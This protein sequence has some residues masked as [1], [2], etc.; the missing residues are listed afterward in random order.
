MSSPRS[1]TLPTT[2]DTTASDVPDPDR[3]RTDAGVARC[4]PCVARRTV[5]GAALAGVGLLAGGCAVYGGDSAAPAGDAAAPATGTGGEAPAT[6]AVLAALSDLPVGEGLVLAD[7][8]VVLT[9]PDEDT[10]LGFS[11]VCTHAGCNVNEVA[12]GLIKCP[13]HGSTFS[14]E[15]GSVTG[16]PAP[17]PLAAVGVRIDGES[18]VRA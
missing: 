18:V 3:T 1:T 14:A 16:G 2:L 6:G 17:S 10:V 7:E 15:D 5:V 9:R 8:G 4:G 11:S 13:C 12:D